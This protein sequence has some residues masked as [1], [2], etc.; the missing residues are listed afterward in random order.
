MIAGFFFNSWYQK[1]WW[2]FRYIPFRFIHDNTLQTF[3]EMDLQ[4]AYKVLDNSAISLG[5]ERFL[6]LMHLTGYGSAT[7]IT[8]FLINITYASIHIGSILVDSSNLLQ[9]IKHLFTTKKMLK[10]LILIILPL[11]VSF[12]LYQHYK[13]LCER[14]FLY[15]ITAIDHAKTM[16]T[17]LCNPSSTNC[18]AITNLQV[19]NFDS[20]MCAKGIDKYKW[21]LPDSLI[22]EALKAKF[23]Y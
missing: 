19:K 1:P 18:C 2:M 13:Q 20:M 15:K 12:G 23:P 10:T 17:K 6:V 8:I 9:S 4:T 11:I 14:A 16:Q 5:I 22:R 7:F 21:Y 3:L